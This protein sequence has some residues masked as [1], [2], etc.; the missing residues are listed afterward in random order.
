MPSRV[1]CIE[2]SRI[3]PFRLSTSLRYAWT[4]GFSIFLSSSTKP[5]ENGDAAI[6]MLFWSRYAW[7]WFFILVLSL[8]RLALNLTSSLMS[9]VSFDGT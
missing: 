7:I 5:L 1:S 2:A 3:S 6:E 4:R 8:T 9:I